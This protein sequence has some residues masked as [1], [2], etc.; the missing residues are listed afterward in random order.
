MRVRPECRVECERGFN[1]INAYRD[2][3][4]PDLGFKVSC[5]APVR[6]FATVLAR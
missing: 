2:G 3:S 4:I 6:P 1:V 5:S